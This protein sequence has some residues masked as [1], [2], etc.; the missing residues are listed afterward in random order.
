MAQ[1]LLLLAPRAANMHLPCVDSGHREEEEGEEDRG[2]VVSLKQKRNEGRGLA[3]KERE[4]LTLVFLIPGG[5][6]VTP[7]HGGL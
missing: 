3:E 1:P 6:C 4:L 5:L 2:L 7:E